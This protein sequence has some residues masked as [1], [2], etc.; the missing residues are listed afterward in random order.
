MSKDAVKERELK[1]FEG[2]EF[3]RNGINIFS[4]QEKKVLEYLFSL[5]GPYDKPDK[6]YV[7]DIKTICKV[8][9]FNTDDTGIYIHDVHDFIQNKLCE[10]LT[11]TVGWIRI[12]GGK[13]QLAFIENSLQIFDDGTVIFR[14]AESIR[15]YLFGLT[16]NFTG[17]QLLN[18]LCLH[19][20]YAIDLFRILKSYESEGECTLILSQLKESLNISEDQYPRFFDFEKRIL[21]PSQEEINNYCRDF[22]FSYEVAER[23][24]RKVYSIRFVIMANNP[25]EERTK[26]NET[27][28]N[29]R[30]KP[31]R[32]GKAA[33]TKK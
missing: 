28:R 25:R 17:Y 19:S 7:T 23:V 29:E 2:N 20:K 6:K 26:T 24:K 18:V 22:H 14:F 3:I 15:K 27:N 1:V 5:V 10:D 33:E 13:Q 12:D 32:Y 30:M 31:K 11:R 16:A 9:N 8:C 4:L 21:K